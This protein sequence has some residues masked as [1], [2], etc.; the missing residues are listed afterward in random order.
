MGLL[1]VYKTS[2]QIVV[3]GLSKF[4]QSLYEKKSLFYYKQQEIVGEFEYW[5]FQL[6]YEAT[7]ITDV[8]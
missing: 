1:S 5:F 4:E 7:N 2:T 3:P 8:G 6:Q